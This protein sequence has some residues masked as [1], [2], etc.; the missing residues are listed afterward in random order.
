[1]IEEEEL[2]R[3]AL[4]KEEENHD[5]D[6]DP[7]LIEEVVHTFRGRRR[8]IVGYVWIATFVVSLFTFYCG[9]RFIIA[10]TVQTQIGWA[11]GFLYFALIVAMLK[12][13]YWDEMRRYTYLREIKRL[14]I[15]VAKLTERI[16]EHLKK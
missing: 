10:E 6:Y 13:W 1:M 14:E 3:Q 15:Q 5:L 12:L 2:L 9:Y 4:Q 16:E 11:T 8:W 7:G